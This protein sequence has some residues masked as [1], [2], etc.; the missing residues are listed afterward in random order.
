MLIVIDG[1]NLLKGVSRGDMVSPKDRDQF[2]AQLGAYAKRKK[3]KATIVFDGGIY[4]WPETQEGRFVT[5]VSGAK[6]T[7]DDYIRRLIKKKRSADLLLVSTD[8]ELGRNASRLEVPVIDAED[9]YLL[10]QAAI[11]TNRNVDLPAGEVEKTSAEDSPELDKL[12]RQASVHVSIKEEDLPRD[13]D[14]GGKSARKLSRVEKKLLEKL[15]K[16]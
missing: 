13:T 8:R 9:F 11:Q 4:G 1:Y 3:H 12:M 6:E 5:V 15:K 10:M 16:L 14:G 2:I 7:A